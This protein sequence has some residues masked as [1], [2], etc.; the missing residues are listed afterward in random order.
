VETLFRFASVRDLISEC[1]S[2]IGERI[3]RFNICENLRKFERCIISQLGSGLVALF[4]NFAYLG[5]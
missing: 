5:S 4:A 3:E 1:G 2:E